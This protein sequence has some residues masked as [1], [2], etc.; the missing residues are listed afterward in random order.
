MKQPIKKLL[1]RK[2]GF[3]IADGSVV[4]MVERK[5]DALGAAKKVNDL[6]VNVN[7]A[8][9]S[10]HLIEFLNDTPGEIRPS[11]LSAQTVLRPLQVFAQSEGSVFAVLGKSSKDK[12][13][14]IPP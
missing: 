3:L 4:G 6:T 7:Y 13:A 5:L 8:L 9:K 2:L 14:K 11:T 1:L 10:S 12:T